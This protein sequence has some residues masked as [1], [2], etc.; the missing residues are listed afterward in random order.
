MEILATAPVM[1]DVAAAYELYKDTYNIN[2]IYF[3][4]ALGNR[5][6]YP[7]KFSSFLCRLLLFT[8]C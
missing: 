6:T 7:S 4:S 5:R 8:L 3:G 2:F 1:R